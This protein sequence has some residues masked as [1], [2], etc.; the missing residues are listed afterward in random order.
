MSPDEVSSSGTN[1]SI[2]TRPPQAAQASAATGRQRGD[3]SRPSG[4]TYASASG[5]RKSTG[6]C[7]ATSRAQAPTVESRSPC[8][9]RCATLS[10]HITTATDSGPASRIHATRLPGRRSATNRPTDAGAAT[11][12]TN[13]TADAA[14]SDVSAPRPSATTFTTAAA[15]AVA[16]AVAAITHATGRSALDIPVM[17]SHRDA[18]G[19]EC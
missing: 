19:P 18:G 5:H 2:V 9:A 15:I 14:S 4:N 11:E 3:G 7:W 13:S 16:T 6:H 10:A 17:L 12:I 1:T 8:S